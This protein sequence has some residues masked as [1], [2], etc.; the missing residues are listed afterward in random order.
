MLHG[1]GQVLGA[2][3]WLDTCL[4]CN[5]QGF[6]RACACTLVRVCRGGECSG[7]LAVSR[8]V[9]KV[10]YTAAAQLSATHPACMCL[11]AV[12]A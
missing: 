9:T 10:H 1:C 2:C 7:G 6:A 12:H 4:G 11:V 3:V 5:T 8:H